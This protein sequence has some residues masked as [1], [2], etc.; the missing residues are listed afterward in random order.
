MI[1][2]HL[3][4]KLFPSE[5][6]AIASEKYDLTILIGILTGALKYGVRI[7][8]RRPHGLSTLKTV[9]TVEVKFWHADS[10][11]KIH[12][13]ITVEKAAEIMGYKKVDA[14][15]SSEDGSSPPAHLT[16]S[17]PEA[18]LCME[19]L[20]RLTKQD[21]QQTTDQRPGSY[22]RYPQ[23]AN[24][25]VGGVDHVLQYEL[26]FNFFPFGGGPQYNSMSKIY[27]FSYDLED[28]DGY[29]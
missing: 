8:S 12:F 6:E 16:R 23:R 17:P 21:S 20:A 4:R 27:G 13:G 11:K 28:E 2:R 22:K 7:D 19:G 3:H 10:T 15:L 5:L 24:S 9:N 26:L 18:A 29:A 1:G 25:V 14:L